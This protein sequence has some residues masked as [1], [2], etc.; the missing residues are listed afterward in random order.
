MRW[1]L[2]QSIKGGRVCAFN[3]YFKSKRCDDILKFKSEELKVKGDFYDIIEAYQNYKNKHFKVFEKEY[4]DHF[5]DYRDE[6]LEEK[7]IYQ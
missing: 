7:K 3:L 6:N 5:N 1:F 2:R 4:E